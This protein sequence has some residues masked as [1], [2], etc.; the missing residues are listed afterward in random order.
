MS[1]VLSRGPSGSLVALRR[2][3]L[4]T[5]PWWLFSA[6]WPCVST[7]GTATFVTNGSAPPAGAVV[8]ATGMIAITSYHEVVL[9]S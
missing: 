6:R 3:V 9:V 1:I 8:I 4:G 7:P 2:A 5:P